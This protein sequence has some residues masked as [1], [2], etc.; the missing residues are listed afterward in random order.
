[1]KFKN[2][3]KIITFLLLALGTVGCS[4]EKPAIPA[5]E[6]DLSQ[7]KKVIEAFGIVRPE[8]SMDIV[9][10]FNS[11]VTDV[12]VNEG[13]HIGLNEPI[14]TLDLTQYEAQIADCRSELNIAELEYRQIG[15]DSDDLNTELNKL[16]NNIDFTEI[17]YSNA[18]KEFNSNEKLYEEGAISEEKYNQSK[19]NM[20]EIKNDL[21]NLNFEL[22]KAAD[23]ISRKAQS[24][25]TKTAVQMEYITQLKN[26]LKASEDK[27]NKAYIVG[28]QIVSQYE[29][30]A[31]Y[32]I[33][34]EPGHITDIS[35]KAFS[36]ADLDS[37]IIEAD[38][39]EEFI[40]DIQVDARVRIV[41]AADRA[42][43]YRGSVKYISKMAFNNNGET[44]VPIRISIDNK[45]SF[46]L[47]NYN[48]DV[49]IEAQ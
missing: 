13:Q 45:D 23:S 21:D 37:L 29:N 46:L 32:D 33:S 30:A 18:V 2:S 25:T 49:Y 8:E 43:E 42:R 48:V 17:M 4:A 22:N 39:V 11:V 12:P 38:V 3:I 26:K 24:E 27:L 15:I 14:L 44:I 6:V 31:V 36:I 40:K 20:D 28:N 5:E 34:Y 47:P 7:K 35:K 9:I 10:D 1:M 41:P 16:K 19:I